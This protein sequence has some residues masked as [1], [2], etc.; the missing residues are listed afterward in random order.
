MQKKDA[1]RTYILEKMYSA[2]IGIA[3][4]IMVILGVGLLFETV[5]KM[6][7]LP[8]LI[9]IGMTTKILLAPAMGVGVAVSLG[10]NTLIVFC[11]MA[12]ATIGA[13]AINLNPGGEFIL[14]MGEPIGALVAAT[15]ATFVGKKVMGKTQFDMMVIPITALF[16]GGVT[17]ILVYK[18]TGPW[19]LFISSFITNSVANQPIIGAIVIALLWGVLI[20]SPASSAALAIAVSLNPVTSGAA[21]I[22]C[23]AQF[24]GFAV[25]SAKENNPGAILAQLIST[26][27]VQLPNIV[28]NPRILIPSM[29]ATAIVAP[30]ATNIFGVSATSQIAG[31]GLCS[32]IAPL[33]ILANEGVMALG[34]FI[35]CGV[36][37]TGFIAYIVGGFCKKMGWIRMGDLRIDLG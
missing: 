2:S 30:I 16:A 9:L 32:L 20:I 23:T 8:F 15:V 25:I 26:P 12:A 14:S 22:G 29:V 10:S 1:M 4:A 27:K 24:V 28:K 17:G 34:S 19:L 3:H 21:L 6:L 36:I 13:G 7:N 33:Y 31:L 5:G 35:F 11:A 37:L 18:I